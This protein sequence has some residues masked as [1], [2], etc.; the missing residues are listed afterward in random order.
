MGKWT[1]LGSAAVA[2]LML[3]GA[4]AGCGVGGGAG[5]GSKT[6]VIATLLPVTGTSASLGLP[7][8]YG[9]DLAVSQNTDL[10]N[11]YTLKVQNE[12]YQGAS[13]A[14]PAAATAAANKLVAQ[15]DVIAVI[16]PFNS[17]ITKVTMPITNNGGLVSISP[18]NTNPGL[19]LREYAADNSINF[20]LLHP[21]GK[22]NA[23]FRV[24]GTDVVQGAVDAKIAAGAPINAKSVYII[25]DN[26]VYGKGLANFFETNFK[27]GGGTVLGRTSFTANQVSGAGSFAD[28]IKAQNP[29]VVFFGGTT[30]SGVG[31]VKKALVAKGFT[32]PWVGGD[33][34]A[35]DPAWLNTASDGA[36]DTYG[37]VAAP[38]SSKLSGGGASDFVTKYKAFVA[39]KPNNDLIGYS[40]ISY[41]SAMIVITAVKQLIK[42]GKDVTRANVRDAIQNIDYQG[43]TGEIKFDKNGDNAGPKV[44][45]VYWVDPATKQWVFKDQVTG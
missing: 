7:T 1:R 35:D 2:G 8:E 36:G 12:N 40:A 42:D 14:D 44:F 43:I 17:G 24:P 45:A 22:P 30:D 38:D 31:A 19:T 21:A 9:T 15:S 5:G 10:G 25:D 4:L 16:G 27:N 23:Y 13:G 32:K 41:D 33:G 28:T 29:D 11:G 34:I 18:A 39:N 6:I 37:T 20:D 26:T 3:V